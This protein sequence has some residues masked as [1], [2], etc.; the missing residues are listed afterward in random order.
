MTERDVEDFIS[1]AIRSLAKT[2]WRPDDKSYQE[3]CVGEAQDYLYEARN[4]LDEA[5]DE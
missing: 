1:G 2:M 3:E 4:I 5:K